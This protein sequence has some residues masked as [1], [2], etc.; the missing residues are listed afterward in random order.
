[1][2]ATTGITVDDVLLIVAF[3]A[4]YAVF[5]KQLGRA[6]ITAALFLTAAG[7]ACGPA[8]LH[9][10]QSQVGNSS[11]ELLASIALATV[12]FGDATRVDLGSLRSNAGTPLRLLTIG[13]LGTMLLGMLIA[14]PL[15][16]VAWPVALI[17]AVILAPTD[18]ALG[19]SVV[20]NPS[21][22]AKVRQSLFVESGLNDGLAV[23]VLV[24]ALA[25]AGLEDS[26]SIGQL[27]AQKLLLSPVIGIALSGLAYLGLRLA[28]RHGGLDRLWAG[29][30]PLLVAVT[31]YLLTEHLGGSGFIAAFVGGVAFG[32]LTRG[33]ASEGIDVD[34]SVSNLLQGATWFIF[35]ALAV[36]PLLL[37]GI[38]WSWVAYAALSLTVVRMLPVAIALIG[39][40]QD[41]R[42]VL[43]IGWFGPRGMASV[44][45]LMLVLGLGPADIDG[46]LIAGVATLTVVASIVLHG[47][48]APPLARRLGAAEQKLASGRPGNQGA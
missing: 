9:W 8:A 40:H 12:L 6:W 2:E 47:L 11:V 37:D 30:V 5:A 18:A 14:P 43:F 25:W 39:T 41:L 33:K 35:G 28:R 21:V 7:A 48:S 22:P 10:F 44:V 24:V 38:P 29:V 46:R 45:F 23:P 36:G 3:L 15:L 16:G 27:L 13:L 1:M 17:L 26:V 42:T 4:V 31:A 20:E 19:A 32:T 34:E